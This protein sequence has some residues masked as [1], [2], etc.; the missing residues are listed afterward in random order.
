MHGETYIKIVIFIVGLNAC[1]YD[2]FTNCVVIVFYSLFGGFDLV[3]SSPKEGS[4][5]YVRLQP[6]Y[7][8]ESTLQCCALYLSAM[9]N[10]NHVNL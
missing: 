10:V 5:I 6:L 1:V 7:N 9:F 2:I 3:S 8:M 4:Y